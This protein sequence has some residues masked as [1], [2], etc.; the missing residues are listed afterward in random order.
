MVYF[1][2]NPMIKPVCLGCGHS[3]C[4]ACIQELIS[5]ARSR[6]CPACREA[7][8]ASQIRDNVALGQMISEFPVH[9][10]SPGCDWKGTYGNAAN[11]HSS[12]PKFRLQCQNEEC[13]HVCQREDLPMHAASC[14]K[15]KVPCPE[16]GMPIKNELMDEHREKGCPYSV[17]PC[18]LSCGELLSRYGNN[19]YVIMK[20]TPC[21]TPTYFPR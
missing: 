21:S 16:C 15:R 11:H 12:C 20:C 3:G 13:Q 19:F 17:E 5:N 4:K 8:D 14:V 1:S 7:V 2:F 10:L 18:P 6:R 9:C